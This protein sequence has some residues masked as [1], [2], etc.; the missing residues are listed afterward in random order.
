MNA[1]LRQRCRQCRGKLPAPTESEHRGFCTRFCYDRFYR[2]RCR[3]CERDLRKTG[4]RGDAHRLYC[5]PPSRCSAEARKWPE[6]YDFWP[7]PI[8]LPVSRKTNL[9]S[10]D[11]TGTF[12]CH[13]SDRPIAFCLRA[14]WWGGDP[15]SGDHSLSDQDGLTIARI[16]LVD[17]RY[18]LRTPIAIPRH[19][20]AD[21][22]EA[23][24]GAECVALMAMP[25]QSVDPKL[26]ARI[27]KDN[28]MPHPIGAP[29]NRQPSQ[30]A[31]VSD[32]KPTRAG[33]DMPDI[34]EV[35]RRAP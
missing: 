12:S 9:R 11:E 29:L 23:K 20:W 6:K 26:A 4:K 17:G 32:W 28:T 27:R 22:E 1:L 31:T 14:W 25:L 19:S 10:A 24:R 30:G 15:G 8:P 16:V 13:N 2:S 21:L 33:T 35:L 3:V 5:R 7:Q 34:P 18:H